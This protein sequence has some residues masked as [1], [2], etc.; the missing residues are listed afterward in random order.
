MTQPSTRPLMSGK[1]NTEMK[2][3][4]RTRHLLVFSIFF[5]L[6]GCDS[7]EKYSDGPEIARMYYSN[8][9]YHCRSGVI[10]GFTA[11]IRFEVIDGTS[12]DI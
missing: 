12:G 1:Q 7:C 3:H 6:T 9:T 4:D 5:M 10:A 8:I 2:A 11:H